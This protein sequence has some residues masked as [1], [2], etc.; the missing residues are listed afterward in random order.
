MVDILVWDIVLKEKIIEGGINADGS[1]AK[2]HILIDRAFAAFVTVNSLLPDRVGI[3]IEV[4]DEALS[5]RLARNFE[6]P[7]PVA[8]RDGR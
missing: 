8:A 6:S 3:F 7:L 1:T 4:T 2:L 5:R